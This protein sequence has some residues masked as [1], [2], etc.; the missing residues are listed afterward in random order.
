MLEKFKKNYLL[1]EGTSTMKLSKLQMLTARFESIRMDENKTFYNFYVE[2]RTILNST[3]NLDENFPNPKV[4]K[5]ILRS[6][7][8]RDLSLGWQS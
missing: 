1:H 6:L 7:P 8:M 5:Q 2:W 4:I 3:F